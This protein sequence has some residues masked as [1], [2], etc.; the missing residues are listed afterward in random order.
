MKFNLVNLNLTREGRNTV[1]ASLLSV[2]PLEPLDR[3][4]QTQQPLPLINQYAIVCLINISPDPR[5]ITCFCVFVSKR[6][7]GQNG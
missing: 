7:L 5:V 2:G 4:A 1:A 3:N 6:F